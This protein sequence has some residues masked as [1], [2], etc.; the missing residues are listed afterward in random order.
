MAIFLALM[1]VHC[2]R[3]GKT[4]PD[5]PHCRDAYLFDFPTTVKN[6]AAANNSMIQTMA[7]G[8][9]LPKAASYRKKWT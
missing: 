9:P 3:P 5:P 6:D 4:M 8:A 2:M 1:A 7:E